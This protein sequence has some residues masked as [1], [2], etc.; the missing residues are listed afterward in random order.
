MGEAG[1]VKKRVHIIVRGLVQGVSFRAY[2]QRMARTLLLHGFV[3][4]LGNG[5]VEIVAEGEAD[6]LEQLVD[7]ARHGPPSAE[8]EEIQ[9]EYSEPTHAFSSFTIP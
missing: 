7:W 2:T 9:V 4:N 8:V 6:R 1:T 3:R 5:D